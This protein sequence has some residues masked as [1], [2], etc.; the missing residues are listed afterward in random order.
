MVL[1]PSLLLGV[2]VVGS[3]TAYRPADRPAK[4]SF[5]DP[6]NANK[7]GELDCGTDK[8]STDL[9][10]AVNTCLW[11]DL[12]IV[13][14]K[15]DH[16]P[17]CGNGADPVAFF[18]PTT[19]CTGPSNFRSDESSIYEGNHDL[20]DKCLIFV[21][22]TEWSMIFRC[23]DFESQAIASSHYMQAIPPNYN[24]DE[25][26]IF[27]ESSVSAGVITPHGSY[28]CTIMKPKEPTYL[29]VD[30]CLTLE[31]LWDGRGLF[32]NKPAICADGTAAVLESFPLPNC[33]FLDENGSDVERE[34]GLSLNKKCY[35]PQSQARSVR[36]HCGEKETEMFEDLPPYEHAAVSPLLI[37]ETVAKPT[38]APVKT[39]PNWQ[40]LPN[41]GSFRKPTS[42]SDIKT[43][44]TKPRGGKIHPYYLSDCETD[45]RSEST[46]V[47]AADTCIWTFMYKSIEIPSPA[48]CSNGTQALFATYSRPG[49]K[50]EDLKY[51]GDIPE[52]FTDSCAD[53]S[54]IDSF[55]FIC[56]GLPE[57]EIGNKGSVGG[58]LKFVGIVILIVFVMGALAV[59]SC[60]LRG[61][62]MM[63]QANE[64][65]GRMLDA[66]KG[67]EGAIQL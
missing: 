35:R 64:L 57:S 63:R 31:D 26:A 18:Y 3:T 20:E 17:K 2:L 32:V 10:L 46:S 34:D 25:S 47:K 28:D 12:P 45:Q 21:S 24:S 61:A 23:E 36:F 37:V 43:Q 15:I 30:T 51:L 40:S 60:C 29:P 11:G 5:F 33:E 14:F 8:E 50:P 39:T 48:I 66:F 58:F 52:E 62:A 7:A 38:P 13:N 67:R 44:S 55:A 49:C 56:E 4:I 54:K 41:G 22:P 53:I 42:N 65:W 59:L 1:I 27:G 19:S 9:S 16:R 6:L